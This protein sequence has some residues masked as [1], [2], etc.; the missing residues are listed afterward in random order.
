MYA[1]RILMMFAIVIGLYPI[2]TTNS[3]RKSGGIAPTAYF[4]LTIDYF[5]FTAFRVFSLISCRSLITSP[6]E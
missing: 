2:E 3:K 1:T 5:P 4:P 6:K